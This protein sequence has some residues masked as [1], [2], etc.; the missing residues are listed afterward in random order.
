MFF[1]LLTF[2]TNRRRGSLCSPKAYLFLL[3]PAKFCAACLARGRARQAWPKVLVYYHRVAGTAA[4]RYIGYGRLKTKGRPHRIVAA[5]IVVVHV[6]TAVHNERTARIVRNTGNSPF[7]NSHIHPICTC[8]CRI[9][10]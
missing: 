3:T 6:T 7:I 1:L 8:C 5:H 10:I 9:I 4:P 2:G